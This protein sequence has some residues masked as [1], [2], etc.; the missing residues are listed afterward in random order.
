[1]AME[2]GHDG[3]IENHQHLLLNLVFNCQPLQ[4][5]DPYNLLHQNGI[6]FH[7]FLP[8]TANGAHGMQGNSFM[9]AV[10][11]Y[12]L[13]N[14]TSRPD[15]SIQPSTLLPNGGAGEDSSSQSSVSPLNGIGATPVSTSATLYS[16]LTNPQTF[17]ASGLANRM[18]DFDIG[19][20]L[21]FDDG[22]NAV[23]VEEDKDI[24]GANPSE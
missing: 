14:G 10:G 3:E 20:Y 8:T 13:M 22:E 23:K 24:Y 12:G 11:H 7:G 15:L 6:N 16:P 21:H 19:D 2:H 9:N 18:A 4:G 5:H 17:A 1:M